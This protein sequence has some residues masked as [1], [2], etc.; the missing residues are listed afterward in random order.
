[1][2]NNMKVLIG[3]LI[4]LGGFAWYVIRQQSEQAPEL[5]SL[6]PEWEQ[7]P[8]LINQVSQ[9]E[10]SK[11]GTTLT[12]SKQQDHWVINGGFY[13]NLDPLYKLLQSLNSA[14]IVEAKT[15][16]PDNHDRLELADDDL[17]VSIY[18]QDQLIRSIHLGKTST[19]GRQFI[20]M[21]GEDQTYLVEGMMPV[22]FNLDSWQLKTVLDIPASEVKSVRII[23]QEGNA[24]E[25]S[26][27]P[28]NN[29]WQLSDPVVGYQLK[30]G[31]KPADLAQ[32]LTRLMI[33]GADQQT[34]ISSLQAVV[35]LVYTLNDD[36]TVRLNVYQGTEQQY[37]TITGER[38]QRYADWV[39][40]L[41]SYKFDALNIRTED[42]LEPAD[43]IEAVS[44]T[45]DSE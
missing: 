1:M 15:A 9:V 29:Q 28:Q 25:V 35:S 21:A 12:V 37:L 26:K 14:S 3:L 34:D 36:S 16:N 30:E 40:Q 5:E 39:M 31:V 11:Q 41:A 24:F 10:L 4:V 23:P 43:V 17:L 6:M 38:Q 22:T 2:I 32:G 19:G 13:A 8:A 20:R 33:D 45:A 7:Q 42:Y 44:E 18:R 27:D